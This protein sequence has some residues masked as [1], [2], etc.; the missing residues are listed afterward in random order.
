MATSIKEFEEFVNRTDIN[1][2]SVDVKVVEQN[3]MFQEHFA[4]IIFYEL[5]TNQS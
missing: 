1:V 4:G 3:S 2:I 5:L